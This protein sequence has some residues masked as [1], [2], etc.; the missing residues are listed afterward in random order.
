MPRMLRRGLFLILALGGCLPSNYFAIQP[1]APDPEPSAGDDESSAEMADDSSGSPDDPGDSSNSSSTGSS[2]EGSAS[3]SEAM[4]SDG[5]SSTGDTIEGSTGAESTA[6]PVDACGD[7]EVQEGE[8][9]DDA[10][11]DDGDGCTEHC[12][13]ERRVFLTSKTWKSDL[14]GIMGAV[15]ICRQAAEKAGI[16]RYNTF[17]PWLSDSDHDVLERMYPGK[18][19]YL[20]V[21]GLMIAP[22]FDALLNKQLQAPIEVDEYGMFQGGGVWTGTRADGKRAADSGHCQ[23]WNGQ[24]PNDPFALEAWTGCATCFDSKWTIRDKAI[25]CGGELSI[26]CFEGK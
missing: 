15:G 11:L 13:R 19:P 21:D 20:R 14:G 17:E 23:N 2:E 26:Y 5:T 22:N 7:G 4:A 9:C 3:A 16:P 24:D 1:T 10:N 12:F 18:G 6:G 8:E 25:D